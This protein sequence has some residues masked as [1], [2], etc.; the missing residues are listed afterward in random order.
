MYMVA[1]YLSRPIAFC[2]AY[3]INF[4]VVSFSKLTLRWS[5]FWLEG[6]KV[7]CCVSLLVYFIFYF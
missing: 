1:A 7:C 4:N 3:N 5:L 6:H 2:F